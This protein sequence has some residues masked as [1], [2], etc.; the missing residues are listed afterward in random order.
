MSHQ[1]IRILTYKRT[2][3]G[4][5]DRLGRFGI[6]DCM[7]RVRDLNFD[8]VIGVGGKG[9]EPVRCGIARKLTWVGI[10]PR[11]S[12]HG[13]GR[14]GL[15]EFDHFVLF[16]SAGPEL[17]AVA[18]NLARLMYDRNRRFVLDSYPEA[19]Y[20]EALQIL[21]MARRNAVASNADTRP[22]GRKCRPTKVCVSRKCPPLPPRKLCR[23]MPA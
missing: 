18:P 16:D 9:A 21:N 20:A 14:G 1:P 6:R 22:G 8:A 5:P 12:F 7:G 19:A 4:D 13:L 17:I 15:V 3:T 2:H 10:G 11:R 23:R